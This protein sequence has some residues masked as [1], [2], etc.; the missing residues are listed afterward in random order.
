MVHEQDV[1][2]AA[3]ARV[4]WIA[5]CGTEVI[6]RLASDAGVQAV[7]EGHAVAVRGR[8]VEHLVVVQRGVL[9]VSMTSAEGKRHVTSR[10]GPGWALGLIPLLDGLPSIHD[11]TAR[12][13]S[14]LVLL[15]RDCLLLAMQRFPTLSQ[16]VMRLLCIRARWGYDMLAAQTLMSLPVRVARLIDRQRQGADGAVLRLSQTDLADML[17]TTRQSLNAELRKLQRA[18]IVALG[19]SRIEVL[20][21]TALKRLGQSGD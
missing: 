13:Q 2:Q 4:P 17:G 20:D 15:P 9:E 6:S 7:A 18:G 11:V 14:D 8:L 1:V 12:G 19:R 3:L 10:A 5:D 16:Q 21:G